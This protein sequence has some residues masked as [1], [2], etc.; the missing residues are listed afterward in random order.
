LTAAPDSAAVTLQDLDPKDTAIL[1]ALAITGI[2]LHNFF[3]LIGPTHQN[4]FTFDGARFPLFIQTMLRP[5]LALQAFFTFFGHFGVQVFIFLSAYGLAKSHWDDDSSWAGFM[6][7]RVKKLYP[8]I[9]LVVLPWVIIN[10]ILAGPGWFIHVLGLQTLLLIL[11]VSTILGFGLPVVGPWWFIAFIVQFYALWLPLRSF[12]KK[13]GWRGLLFLG[14][15]C[16]G[17]IYVANPWLAHFDLNLLV[18]PIGRMTSICMGIAAARYPLRIPGWLAIAS[19]TVLMLGSAYYALWPFTFPSALFLCLW[20]YMA[21]RDSL[22]RLPLLERLG[23]YSL[24]AF[25]LNGLVRLAFLPYAT[26][27]A[28]QLLYGAANLVA[29][30]ACSAIIYEGVHRRKKVITPAR[31]LDC[32][33]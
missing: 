1:K 2:I 14:L 9:G 15:V 18:T 10:C 33:A 22:R 30:F 4:E 21:L 23:R 8:D 25:L 32:E 31:P 20:I 12:A 3:H 6:W 11:G 13:T 5:Q 26:T 17:L 27:P 29:T 19:V 28:K 7:S 16:I 24:L